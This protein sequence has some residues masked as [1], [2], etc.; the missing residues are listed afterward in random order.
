M[1]TPDELREILVKWDINYTW[2]EIAKQWSETHRFYHDLDHL[3]D[4]LEKYPQNKENLLSLISWV[5]KN[6]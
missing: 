5:Y 4:L 6:Y 1:V 3:F 2:Y